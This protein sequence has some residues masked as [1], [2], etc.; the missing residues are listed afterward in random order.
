[1]L[2]TRVL[3]D[4]PDCRGKQSYGNV[5]VRGD[6]VLRGCM[7]CQYSTMVS[8]PE[9]RKKVIYLDQFFFSHAF[10]RGYVRFATALER[11]KR[12]T[13]LQLLVSPY[14][15]VHEDETHQWRGYKDKSHQQLMDFIKATSRGAE[16]EKAYRVEETQV[17]QDLVN[18][19]DQWQQSTQTFD[20][21]VA[22]E[23]HDA[24]KNYLQS[25]LKMVNRIAQGDFNAAIDSPIVATVAEHMLHCLPKET[26]RAEAISRCAEFFQSEHF[27]Q[28][29]NMWISARL[30]ATLKD[31]VKRGAYSNREEARQRLSGVFDDILH[32]SMYAPYCDAFVM[33]TPMA[34]LVR[35]PT[36]GLEQRY[37]VKVFSLNN[38]DALLVWLNDLETGMTEEHRIGIAAAYP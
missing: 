33:D 28:V 34:D 25:Y 6:H 20:Q 15:S 19:F 31:M 24:G 2:V 4:C 18:V 17:V 26:P 27:V 16:F 38:W 1:M 10:R 7:H 32:I 36:V 37:G 30:F 9:I 11:V 13:H 12:M 35:Q 14:S 8:L 29:P 22:L 3:G 5:S 21:D 23:M